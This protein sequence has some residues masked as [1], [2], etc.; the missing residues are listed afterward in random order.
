[1]KVGDLVRLYPNVVPAIQ[2]DIHNPI[3][4][5]IDISSMWPEDRSDDST[6]IMVRYNTGKEYRWYDFQ[7]EMISESIDR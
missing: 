4:M 7:L 1:M 6:F 2:R 5:I 3:G